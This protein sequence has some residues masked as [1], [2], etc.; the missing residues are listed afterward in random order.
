MRLLGTILG[1]RAAAWTCRLIAPL[2]PLVLVWWVLMHYWLALIILAALVVV[3]T[4]VAWWMLDALEAHNL[5]RM[6]RTVAGRAYL[7]TRAAEARV[8]VAGRIP[9]RAAGNPIPAPGD[10]DA[11]AQAMPRRQLRWWQQPSMTPAEA[12]AELDRRRRA[13][14]YVQDPITG[15]W[16]QTNQQEGR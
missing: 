16:S 11:R 3:A 7:D 5:A 4:L 13:R 6:Q 1:L 8:A 15:R 14:G 10:V 2:M 12:L 9:G